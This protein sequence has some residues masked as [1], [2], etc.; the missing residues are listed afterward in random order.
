MVWCAGGGSRRPIRMHTF[1][2]PPLTAL[3]QGRILC[4]PAGGAEPVHLTWYGPDGTEVQTDDAGRTAFGVCAGRYRIVAEDAD[5]Q[6]GE[7]VV[8]VEAALPSAVVVREYRVTPASTGASRDGSVE[9]VGHGLDEGWRF[10]WTHGAET[11]T[12]LLRDVPVG[13]YAAT[14]LPSAE[15][16]VAPFVHL[17]AP[18][19]VGVGGR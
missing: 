16:K 4:R 7:E 9:A 17:C 19:R 15:G 2:E 5:G 11:D 8:D 3:T 13:T 18:A 1:V 6:R 12:P 14:P 10:L